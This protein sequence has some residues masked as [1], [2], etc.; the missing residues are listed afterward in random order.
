MAKIILED[1]TIYGAFK[2]F[3]SINIENA[4]VLDVFSLRFYERV[5]RKLILNCKKRGYSSIL[6]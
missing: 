3:F 2:D 5:T 4:D 6:P 1:I